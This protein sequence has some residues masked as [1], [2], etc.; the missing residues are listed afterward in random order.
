MGRGRQ[1]SHLQTASLL[2][3]G[4]V[5]ELLLLKEISS[6]SNFAK[7]SGVASEEGRHAQSE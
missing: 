2:N 4:F 6:P 3:L 1:E 7:L 5:I